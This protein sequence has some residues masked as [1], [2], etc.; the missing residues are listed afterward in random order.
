MILGILK[1]VDT[2]EAFLT[3]VLAYNSNKLIEMLVVLQ[4]RHLGAKV[5]K[6][7]FFVV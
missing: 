7:E 4:L 2:T 3:E 5:V 1:N 6:A